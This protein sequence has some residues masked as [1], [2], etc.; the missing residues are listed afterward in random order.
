[1]IFRR[2]VFRIFFPAFVGQLVANDLHSPPFIVT[3]ICKFLLASYLLFE[4]LLFTTKLHT[5][6]LAKC[7]SEEVNLESNCT[8]F[9]AN[10]TFQHN[11]REYCWTHGFYKK[12]FFVQGP[13][14]RDVEGH[15]DPQNHR[16]YLSVDSKYARKRDCYRIEYEENDAIRKTAMLIYGFFLVLVSRL[17]D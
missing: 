15:W 14:P 2:P 7:I 6:D 13:N 12:R 3:R 10:A 16:L 5:F 4:V 1:M 17:S 8:N 9:R 11:A